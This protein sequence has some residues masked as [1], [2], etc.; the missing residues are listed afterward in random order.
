MG[1]SKKQQ[2][3]KDLSK[4]L[5]SFTTDWEKKVEKQY[6]PQSTTIKKY[7]NDP[8]HQRKAALESVKVNSQNGQHEKFREAGQKRMKELIELGEWSEK[9]VKGG[10]TSREKGIIQ[11]TQYRSSQ[12]EHECPSCGKK[13]KGNLFKGLHFDNCG[14]EKTFP[15]RYVFRMYNDGVLVGEFPKLKDIAETFGCSTSHM[16]GMISGS[17]KSPVGWVFEKVNIDKNK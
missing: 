12:T 6:I 15:Q 5:E 2:W 16:S 7:S 3:Q 9:V 1:H 10:I 11:E 13:G 4:A 17:K 8:K 14:K